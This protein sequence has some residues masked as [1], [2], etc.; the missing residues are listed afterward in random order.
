MACGPHKVQAPAWM[1]RS[2]ALRTRDGPARLDQAYRRLLSGRP[3][4]PPVAD[5]DRRPARRPGDGVGHGQR[6]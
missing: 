4:D 1:I 3:P 6:R 2:V 5:P